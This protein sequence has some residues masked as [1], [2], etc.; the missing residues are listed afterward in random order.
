LLIAPGDDLLLGRDEDATILLR[1][2]HISRRHA[3]IFA[4][5]R[6]VYIEDLGSKNGTFVN[7]QPVQRAEL[8]DLDCILIG[9][10]RMVV[11]EPSDGEETANS[12]A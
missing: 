5:N 7:D 1:G 3:R 6:R 11:L 4:D 10:L 8:G 2:R 9:D 12:A